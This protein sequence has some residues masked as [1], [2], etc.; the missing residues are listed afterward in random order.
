MKMKNLLET[1]RMSQIVN[2]ILI[3]ILMM[4]QIGRENS[5]D[6]GSGGKTSRG[7]QIFGGNHDSKGGPSEG[8]ASKGSPTSDG[9]HDSEGGTSEARASEGNPT[10]EDDGSGQGPEVNKGRTSGGSKTSEES[11]ER[12]TV[13]ESEGDSEKI[14][15]EEVLKKKVWLNA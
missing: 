9:G 15:I 14:G 11:P 6:V 12:D 13:P 5:E 2:L 3:Q 7:D 10:S 1:L 8:G 4:I